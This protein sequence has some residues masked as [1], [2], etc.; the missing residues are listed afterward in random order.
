MAD[1]AGFSFHAVAQNVHRNACGACDARRRLQRHLW[2]G[3][4]ARIVAVQA[5]V[6]WLHALAAPALQY[7]HH[8]GRQRNLVTRD[9]GQRIGTGGRSATVGPDAMSI[10][11]S[12]GTSEI[13]RVVT[14][15]G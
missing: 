10:G 4:E 15:A 1:I 5:R 6:V 3:D 13:R 8:L 9:D 7:F 2:R 14:F 11:R 12:P